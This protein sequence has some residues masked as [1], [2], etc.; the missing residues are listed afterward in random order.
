MNTCNFTGRIANDIQLKKTQNGKSVVNFSLAC[1]RGKDI[2]EFIPIVLW[3]QA[4]DY[5]GQYAKKGDLI[6]IFNGTLQSRKW[7]EKTI[8]EVHA[9]NAEILS[10]SESNKRQDDNSYSASTNRY[11]NEQKQPSWSKPLEIDEEDLPFF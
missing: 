3:G 1:K 10:H 11:Q 4:A 2:T 8:W 9:F 5:I 7:E 6:G